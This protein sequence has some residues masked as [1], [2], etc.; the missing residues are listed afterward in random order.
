MHQ[1]GDTVNMPVAA[2]ADP[3]ASLSPI[4]I[5]ERVPPEVEL[6]DYVNTPNAA[7]KA[8]SPIATA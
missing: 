3:P 6:R 7:I 8:A 4:R 1:S 2:T 5:S